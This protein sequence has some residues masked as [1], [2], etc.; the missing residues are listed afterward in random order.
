MSEK[1]LRISVAVDDETRHLIENLAKKENKTI[2]E[3]IRRAILL[4]YN[5][6]SKK[7]I[8][9]NKIETY[10]DLLSGGENIAVDI[11][12]WTVMLDEINKKSSDEFW[13]IIERIGYEHGIEYK[14]KGLQDIRSILKHMESKNL[15]ELKSNGNSYILILTTRNEQRILKV[16]LESLFKALNIPVEVVEGLKKLIII[17]KDRKSSSNT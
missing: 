9:L 12:L 6:K 11:E 4:Y 17:V 16:Y 15:F 13:K 14:S 1:L 8:S 10:I 2:S 3:I 5:L 7:E